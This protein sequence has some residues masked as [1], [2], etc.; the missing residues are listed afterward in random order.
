MLTTHN[1]PSQVAKVAADAVQ[2]LFPNLKN[3]HA[4][5]DGWGRVRIWGYCRLPSGKKQDAIAR[6][7]GTATAVKNFIARIN[8]QP[9]LKKAVMGPYWTPRR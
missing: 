8:A 5:I 2:I 1:S 9:E 4:R 3:V 6:G 7:Y